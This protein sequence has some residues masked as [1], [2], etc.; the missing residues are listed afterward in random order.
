MIKIIVIL[1]AVMTI[2][3]CSAKVKVSCDVNNK[4]E[5]LQQCKEHPQFGIAIPF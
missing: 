2:C 5:I 4:E 3:S 1:I